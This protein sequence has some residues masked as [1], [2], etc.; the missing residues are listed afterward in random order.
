MSYSHFAQSCDHQ[1]T[2]VAK[3]EKKNAYFWVLI[4][5][6][7]SKTHTIEYLRMVEIIIVTLHWNV[8]LPS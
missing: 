6:Y 5:K 7:R 2:K 3:P 8:Q 1:S 4:S